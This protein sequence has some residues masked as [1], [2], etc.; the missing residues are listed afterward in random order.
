MCMIHLEVHIIQ[1]RVNFKI[2]CKEVFYMSMFDQVKMELICR[3]IN[4]YPT[5]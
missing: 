1:D 5:L 2:L 4:G 3:D